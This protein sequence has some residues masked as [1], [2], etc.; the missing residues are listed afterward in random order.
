MEDVHFSLWHKME[1]GYGL[2]DGGCALRPSYGTIVITNIF[3]HIC[4]NNDQY[5]ALETATTVSHPMFSSTA[6]ICRV[7]CRVDAMNDGQ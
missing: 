2:H 3:H 6:L 7:N 5:M 1:R 4:M